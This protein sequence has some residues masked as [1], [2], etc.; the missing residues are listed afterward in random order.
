VEPVVV[1]IQPQVV[2]VTD[3]TLMVQ[4]VVQAI[5]GVSQVVLMPVAV[6]LERVTTAK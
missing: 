3:I 1:D 6:V 5:H 4:M 2:Q